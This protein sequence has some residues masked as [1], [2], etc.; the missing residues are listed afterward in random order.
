MLKVHNLL[1]ICAKGNNGLKP[2]VQKF[3]KMTN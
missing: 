2:P 1:D 3:H